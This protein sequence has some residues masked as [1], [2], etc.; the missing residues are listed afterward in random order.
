MDI[1]LT[2]IFWTF[3]KYFFSMDSIYIASV[4]KDKE[5][6]Y[7]LIDNTGTWTTL[8]IYQSICKSGIDTYYKAYKNNALEIINS[9]GEKIIESSEYN[10]LSKLNDFLLARIDKK[11]GLININGET[12]ID[13]LYD[14]IKEYNI[15]NTFIVKQNDKYGLINIKTGIL[16]EIKYNRIEKIDKEGFIKVNIE[17]KIGFINQK[18]EW[19]INPNFD[20]IHDFEI[21]GIAKAEYEDKWGYINRK[22]E[23]VIPTVYN[24]IYPFNDEE[25]AT[26]SI[27][28]MYGL[29]DREGKWVIQPRF[30][31]INYYDENNIIVCSNS[32]Y[33]LIDI[34]ENWLIDPIFDLLYAF[35]DND[36]AEAGID[37]KWGVI[38]R[39][40]EWII[41]PQ[42]DIILTLDNTLYKVMLNYKW[43]I[44][45]INN[46][47]IVEPIYGEIEDFSNFNDITR[48]LIDNKY[49]II[50]KKG[51]VVLYPILNELMSFD[52]NGLALAQLDNSKWGIINTD[53]QWIIQPVYDSLES[54]DELGNIKATIGNKYGWIDLKGNW[55]IQ[56]VFDVRKYFFDELLFIKEFIN[57]VFVEDE[58]INDLEGVYFFDDITITKTDLFSTNFNINFVENIEY[59]ILYDDSI[60]GNF[61]SGIAMCKKDE[62]YFLICKSFK[63]KPKIF[64]LN[65]ELNDNFICSM[66]YSEE[67]FHL[68]INSQTKNTISSSL[69]SFYNAPFLKRFVQFYE[70]LA[71]QNG[72]IENEDYA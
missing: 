52:T 7:G 57:D 11:Y 12:I 65:S 55:V 68:T 71:I 8:P 56:P 6:C 10:Y 44:I 60:D 32:K 30:S 22:G 47:Y 40:G 50:N 41:E 23:W 43:G 67:T 58:L 62:D 48:V 17:N 64:S 59:F 4:Y 53:G 33:G 3:I 61:S 24:F 34:K 9:N 63:E 1:I 35:N 18:G 14:S 37:K 28:S 66:H 21:K 31:S 29:I 13:F 20:Y 5:L 38:N 15:G 51:D 25:F 46:N 19:L 39:K 26:V 72:W 45:D 69:M 70:D 54:I 2:K 36:I 27:G 16:L 49:G 42:Y